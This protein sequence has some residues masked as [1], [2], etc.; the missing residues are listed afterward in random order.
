MYGR[1]KKLRIIMSDNKNII[2]SGR[3]NFF[4]IAQI[5]A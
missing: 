5:S 2:A 4:D 3:Y 1:D